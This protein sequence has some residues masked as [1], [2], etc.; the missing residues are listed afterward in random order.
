MSTRVL[1][2]GYDTAT[3]LLPDGTVLVVGGSL[4]ELFDPASGTFTSPARMIRPRDGHTATLLMDGTVLV[5]GGQY[6]AGGIP[7][8]TA[9]IYHPT[10]SIPAPAL[11]S[12]SGDGRGQAAIWHATTGQ[13]A[14]SDSPAATGEALSMYT[15]SLAEGGVIPPQIS[16]GGKLAQVLF[17]GPAP[18]YPGYYQVN[19]L[20]PGGVSPGAAVPVRLTY[21]GRSSN[22]VTIG[23]Q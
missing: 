9:E 14:S 13:I 2:N 10:V 8:P 23:V 4:G 1:I 15:T 17:F 6:V 11:L 7:P 16:I 3:A 19:F 22:S 5:V 21:I 12:L 18:G 20:V